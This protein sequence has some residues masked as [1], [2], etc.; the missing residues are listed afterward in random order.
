[1]RNSCDLS[2]H[3]TVIPDHFTVHCNL[4]IQRLPNSK[5]IVA[6]RKLCAINSDDLRHDIVVSHLFLHDQH[7]C[8]VTALCDQLRLYAL[9]HLGL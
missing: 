1:M 2:F 9:F 7:A 3:D 8:D 4:N 5:T 6:Y